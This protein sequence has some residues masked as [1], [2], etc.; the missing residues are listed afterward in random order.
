MFIGQTPDTNVLNQRKKQPALIHILDSQTDE[1]TAVIG[2]DQPYWE[3]KHKIAL[4]KNVETFDFHTIFNGVKNEHIKTGA[5]ATIP[6]GNGY[7][8]EMIIDE[9]ILTRDALEVYSTGSHNELKKA[10]P[11]YPE[12]YTGATIDTILDEVLLNTGWQRGIT[13]YSGTHK[14]KW[15]DYRSPFDA[16]QLLPTIFD[17][18]LRFRVE[19][20]SGKLYRFVDAVRKRGKDSGKEIVSGKDLLNVKRRDHIKDQVTALLGI[21]PE[22]EDGTRLVVEVTDGD[23]LQSWGRN[24]RHKW[25]VYEPDS[26][27]EDMTLDELERYTRTELDKRKAAAVE[28]EGKAIDIAQAFGRSHEGIHIGYTSR[29]K[30]TEFNP[31]IY[32]DS[33]IIEVE[34]SIADD[35]QKTFVLGE[36]IEHTEEDINKLRKQLL[37]KIAGKTSIVYQTTPPEDT[38][39]TWGDTSEGGGFKRYAADVGM[40]LPQADVTSEN[41]AKDTAN[42]AGR[43]SE[44]IEDKQGAQEKASKALEDAKVDAQT[45]ANAAQTAAEEYAL[46]KADLAETQ[47]K[48]HADGK[49]TAE[50]QARIAAD[51]EKLNQAKTHADQAASNAET[52]AKDYADARLTNYVTAT[53]YDSEMSDLQAQIDNQVQSHFYSYEP[54]LTNVP[55]SDWTTIAEKDKHVGDLFFDTDKGHSYRF[56]KQSGNYRWV[57]V[58]DEGIAKALEDAS[59]AQDTADNKRRVFV[60]QPTTPY[61]KGDLWNDNKK[62]KQSTVTKTDSATFS[63]SDWE[64]IGDVTGE[65]TAKDTQYVNGRPAKTIEDVTG[66]QIKAD[67]AEQASKKYAEGKAN[68]AETQAKAY[69]DGKITDEEQARIDADKKAL[70]E[71]EKRIDNSVANVDSHV[72]LNGDGY[73][74]FSEFTLNKDASS[75]Q[76]KVQVTDLSAGRTLFKHNSH[77]YRWIGLMTEGT[78]RAETGDNLEYFNANTNVE[79]NRV[80]TLTVTFDKGTYKWYQDGELISSHEVLNDTPLLYFGRIMENASYP[81]GF[82]GKVYEIKRWDRPLS[83]DE[84]F[85]NNAAGL[86][87]HWSFD[88]GTGDVVKDNVGGNDGTIVNGSWGGNFVKSTEIVKDYADAAASQAEKNAKDYSVSE[89]V[90][91]NK[92]QDV[93]TDLTAKAEITYV[94]GQLVSKA[95]KNETY[96]ISETDNLLLNKVSVTKF[97]TDMDGVVQNLNANSTLLAQNQE[98]IALKADDSRVDSIAGS[99]SDNSAQLSVQSEEISTKVE[100]STYS[101]DRVASGLDNED[102]KGTVIPATQQGT[103]YRIAK[104]PGNRAWARFIIRDTTSGQH[105][106]A[107]FTAGTMYNKES[108]Q[109][110]TLLSLTKYGSFPFNKARIVTGGTYDDQFLDVFFWEDRDS[111]VQFWIKENIQESGWQAIDWES[112]GAIS[113][114]QTETIYDLTLEDSIG[115]RVGSAESSITQQADE[116]DRRVRKDD[117]ISVINQTPELVR[118][119]A[120]KLNLE[121][122]AKFTDLST[123]GQTT[124]HG[125]NLITSSMKWDVGRGGTMMLGGLN[126]G[127]GVFIVQDDEGENVVEL[128]AADKG[129]QEVRIGNV[130]SSSV[131]KTNFDDYT[132]KIEPSRGDLW[133][134]A[135]NEIPKYNEGNVTVQ[136][137]GSSGNTSENVLVTGF[138][139]GGSITFD[140][141]TSRPKIDGT[142][143]VTRNTN[144]IYVS[145]FDVNGTESPSVVTNA[146]PGSQVDNVTVYGNGQSLAFENQNGSVVFSNLQA[147]DVDR[148]IRSSYA[149][150]L[151][152]IACKGFGSTTGIEARFGGI[153][154]GYGTAPDSSSYPTFEGQ[155]GKILSNFSHDAGSATIPAPPEKTKR[156]KAV[157][158]AGWRP[159]GGWVKNQPLQGEW[160][161]YGSYKGLW[162]FEGLGAELRGKTIKR[163]RIKVKREARG[164]KSADV[165]IR[166][167]THNYTS[168][169]GG[170]PTLGSAVE[171]GHFKWEEDR[172]EGIRS[173]LFPAFENGN[174]EGIGIYGGGY[175]YMSAG[176]VLEVTYQ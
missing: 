90:Y 102:S 36:F 77:S 139:G 18:E 103:W 167:R 22:K 163:M 5:R 106:T 27:R 93:A 45:K 113:T 148:C 33:R 128:D 110:F 19:Q 91:N 38:T 61:D 53:L 143:K 112:V 85:Y 158:A 157:N 84:I 136:I 71:A 11:I 120:N 132:I 64:L 31:P 15:D 73:V 32:L 156:F 151:T 9:T 159:Q 141:Q 149:S 123:E 65:N 34:R 29:I 28:Y 70:K 62:I 12:T 169:P 137:V 74:E 170:E 6:D 145:G 115:R 98:A 133:Q 119:S 144:R 130:L 17:V 138:I 76:M 4:K 56:A 125:G 52:A 142:F 122:Y 16:L 118:I 21:G 79:V 152:V 44:T 172:W 68:L 146:S 161:G 105:G 166:F 108:S 35:S 95:N 165:T 135:I 30:A 63:K 10:K 86:V 114:G 42:V 25:Q 8:R 129:F 72:K 83:K 80:V 174:A 140:I 97:N 153:I 175:A 1:T 47:A 40:W 66:A 24:G 20:D 92:M 88:E 49:I 82:V 50:E 111:S 89:T 43:P 60:A 41:T 75:L 168:I 39:V 100:S 58:R 124:I 107:Q 69:A 104:N 134:D 171:L 48:A 54:T 155:G 126:N 94:D 3:D 117:V 13:D 99:V 96:T 51:T 2:K 154:T 101:K 57:Q 14:I 162:I 37:G 109:D 87:N 173:S 81:D 46:A 116:I 55:A 131:V 176:A 78:I 67:T 59:Q 121:G 26:D 7:Y 150:H 164:G 127:N 160:A 23:A 147:Y